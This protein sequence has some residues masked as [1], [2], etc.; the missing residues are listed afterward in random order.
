MVV[1]VLEGLCAPVAAQDVTCG[2][3][4]FQRQSHGFRNLPTLQLTH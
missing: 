1:E 2:E 3:M 4:P